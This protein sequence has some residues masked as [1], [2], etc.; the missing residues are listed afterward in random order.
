MRILTTE[1]CLQLLQFI[2]IVLLISSKE[3][4]QIY[5]ITEYMI[6]YI[7]IY[8]Y[9]YMNLNKIYFV[10]NYDFIYVIMNNLTMKL[11]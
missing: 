7:Y 6:I 9:I 1:N 2:S 11:F 4:S 5:L 10:R 3:L 8:L